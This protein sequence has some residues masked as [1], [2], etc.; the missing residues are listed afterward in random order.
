MHNSE[1]GFTG[2]EG[3]T[4]RNALREAKGGAHSSRRTTTSGQGGRSWR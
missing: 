2:G 1:A 4:L 3:D